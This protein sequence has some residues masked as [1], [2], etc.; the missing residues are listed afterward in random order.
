VTNS[1]V[2]ALGGPATNESPYILP[3]DATLTHISTAT[4]GNETWT[5]ELRVGGTLVAGASLATVAA[6]SNFASYNI[7]FN[8]GDGVQFYVDGSSVSKPLINAFFKRR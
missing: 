5:A 7:N 4:N 1:Y 3:F 6:S 8:A 2:N